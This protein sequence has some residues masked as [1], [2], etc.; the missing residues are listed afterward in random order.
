MVR[1]AT[2][3]RLGRRG[4]LSAWRLRRRIVRTATVQRRGRRGR[5]SAVASSAGGAGCAL[6]CLR[7]RSAG[8]R[9]RALW[10][11]VTGVGRDALGEPFASGREADVYA[12]DA[13][14]V[15]RRYRGGGDASREAA[16]MAYA[17]SLGY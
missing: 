8:R 10:A 9:R 3:P 6:W 2:V 4:R 16:V 15:L 13:G 1:R 7:R 17:A 5:V 12:L 14:T 11:T